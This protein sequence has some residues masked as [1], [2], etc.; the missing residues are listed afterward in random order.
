MLRVNKSPTRRQSKT[1][2]TNHSHSQTYSGNFTHYAQPTDTENK[3]IVK[4]NELKEEIKKTET[5]T[6]KGFYCNHQPNDHLPLTH[7]P[8]VSTYVKT[9]DQ[10]LNIFCNL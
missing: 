9:E 2:N 5:R 8:A 4:I 3:G 6:R 7:Q 1:N 10:I